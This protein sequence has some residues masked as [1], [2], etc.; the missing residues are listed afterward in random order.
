M[1]DIKIIEVP[2]WGLSMEEGTLNSWLIEEG[3]SFRLHQEVCEET[4]DDICL[5][6]Y[7]DVCNGEHCGHVGKQR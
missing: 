3:D 7:T 2:K 6:S 4:C 5:L 1:T